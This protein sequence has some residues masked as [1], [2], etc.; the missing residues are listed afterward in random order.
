MTSKQEAFPKFPKLVCINME[1]WMIISDYEEWRGKMQK[2]LREKMLTAQTS[3]E[4]IKL[5][6]Q[7]L[8]ALE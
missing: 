2:Q 8:E 6:K 7:F 4:E 1:G 3:M 5:I